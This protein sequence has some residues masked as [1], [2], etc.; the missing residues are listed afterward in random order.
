MGS[1]IRFLILILGILLSGCATNRKINYFNDIAAR[2]GTD[3][4][5]P[6]RQL[7]IQPGDVLQITITTFDKDISLIFNPN[8]ANPTVPGGNGMDQGYLVDSSGH[9]NLPVIGKIYVKDETTSE[10]NDQVKQQL[11]QT[12]QNVYVSTRLVNFKVSV[13]GDVARPGSFR[14]GAERASILDALAMAGD[15]TSTAVRNDVMVI[16]EVNGEK[17][18]V[19][20]NLNDSKTLSSPYYYL[21]N[22]DVVY[23]KSG[24]G[25]TWPTSRLIVL[26]PA[27]ISAIS[28]VTTIVLLHK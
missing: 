7:R 20:L 9:I 8:T 16:R 4:L 10:I 5:Q 2:S 26:L 1:I 25:R 21:V 6:Y 11:S 22:N 28:L 17:T 3:S 15:M 27:I 19:T 23:V 18:Y 13:L 12:M 24:P 14:I